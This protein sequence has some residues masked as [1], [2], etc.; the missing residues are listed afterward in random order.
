MNF[1]RTQNIQIH[2][3][4]KFVE[5]TKSFMIVVFVFKS[6]VIIVCIYNIHSYRCITVKTSI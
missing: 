6:P 3:L 5:N 2:V 1:K 4:G